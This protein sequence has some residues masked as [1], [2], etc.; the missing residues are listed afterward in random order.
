VRL[1][2]IPRT[3]FPQLANDLDIIGEE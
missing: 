2:A 3:F 1:L